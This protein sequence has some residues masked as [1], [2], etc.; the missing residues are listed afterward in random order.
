MGIAYQQA[1]DGGAGCLSF[2]NLMEDL[3]TLEISRAQVWQWL[4]HEVLLD[5]GTPVTRELVQQLFDE[6]CRKIISDQNI[7]APAQIEAYW[8]AKNEIEKVFLKSELD[9]FFNN[10][11]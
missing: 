5:D 2:E 4:F 10:E 7:E 9:S 8:K 6:E 11:E 3:A 1:W